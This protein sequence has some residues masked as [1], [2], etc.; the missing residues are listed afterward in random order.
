MSKLRKSLNSALRCT[1]AS[2]HIE[3]C[4]SCQDSLPML[5]AKPS[6]R[7]QIQICL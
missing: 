2:K 3:I 4:V 7:E 5:S 6:L 1:A